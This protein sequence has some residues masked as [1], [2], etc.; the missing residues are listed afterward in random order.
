MR[1]IRFF[2][3]RCITLVIATMAILFVGAFATHGA[4]DDTCSLLTAAPVTAV[5]NSPATMGPG[6]LKTLCSWATSGHGSVTVGF[7]PANQY[8][9]N[10]T[11]PA[12][13]QMVPVS[14]IGDEAFFLVAGTNVGL[15]VKKGEHCVQSDRVL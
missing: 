6:G 8:L 14:G 11:P 1:T 2:Q 3:P 13:I 7:F 5:L 15:F 4:T 12:P 9:A 10:K